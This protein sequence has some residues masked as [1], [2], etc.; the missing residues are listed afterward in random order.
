MIPRILIVDDE[1]NIRQMMKLTLEHAGFEA[2]TA[3][4]GEEGL[5][6][7]G[8]GRGW[9]V[10]VLDQRMPGMSGIDV[11]REMH[12]RAP[13]VKV[14][15]V[16]AFG[17][18]DLATKAVR[19]GAVEFL[20]KPFTAESLR[21]S[22]KAALRQDAAQEAMTADSIFSIFS[23]TTINGFRFELHSKVEDRHS[24]EFEYTFKV[25]K[26]SSEPE[27]CKVLLPA[28]VMELTKAYVDCDTLPCQANFWQ[29]MGEEA[30][31][32]Y[33][34]QNADLPPDSVLKIDNLSQGLQKWLD[35]VLTVNTT[36]DNA[37]R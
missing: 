26:P 10:V 4:D 21:L 14:I 28:Y 23:R 12:G 2:D 16:T 33:L 5:S 29:A 8:D 31:A 19:A 37:A 3:K 30:L 34:W 17:T 13:G 22:V 15:L 18:I 7:F 1:P 9:D 32:S 24:G 35:D 27:M 25:T 6:K 11:Q 36:V 20:R